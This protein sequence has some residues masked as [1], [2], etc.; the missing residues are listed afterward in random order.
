MGKVGSYG[1]C[2]KECPKSW[3]CTKVTVA[4]PYLALPCNKEFKQCGG[5]N[6]KGNPCCEDGLVCHG[7]QPEYFM[8]CT[9]KDDL[10]KK[11]KNKDADDDDDGE[12][13][14][15]SALPTKLNRKQELHE[16]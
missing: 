12:D 3:N 15:L 8:Q 1:Q 13:I 6:F 4:R 9:N 11:S 10:E 7:D 2:R 5:G 14:G 16:V